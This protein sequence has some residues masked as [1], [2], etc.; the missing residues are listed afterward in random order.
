[1]HPTDRAGEGCIRAEKCE[2]ILHLMNDKKCQLSLM[3]P[4][5]VKTDFRNSRRISLHSC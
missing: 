3:F 4:Q 5:I 2:K 1:V